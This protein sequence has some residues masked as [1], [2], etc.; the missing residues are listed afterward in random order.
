M[1]RKRRAAFKANVALAAFRILHPKAYSSRTTQNDAGRRPNF[2]AGAAWSRIPLRR[3][4]SA[5]RLRR[6]CTSKTALCASSSFVRS[7]SAFFGE[8]TVLH[9][10]MPHSAD[11]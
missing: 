2:S 7:G 4:Y 8:S 9:L 6:S 11:V 3:T 5:I 10:K 1:T